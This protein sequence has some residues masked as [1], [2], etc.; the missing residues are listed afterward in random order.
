VTTRAE[1]LAE[2]FATP[3]TTSALPA[4]VDPPAERWEDTHQRFTVWLPRHLVSEAKSAAS[5]RHESIATLVAR[6]L[7]NELKPPAD[8]P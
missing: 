4:G 5:Q 3:S 6:A 8:E 1:R 7:R 2:R